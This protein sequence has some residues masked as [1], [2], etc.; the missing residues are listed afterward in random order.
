MGKSK[1]EKKHKDK[2]HKKAKRSSAESSHIINEV[3]DEFSSRDDESKNIVKFT[4]KRRQTK[5]GQFMVCHDS[6]DII[7][8][9]PSKVT[10]NPSTIYET[11]STIFNRLNLTKTS[12]ENLNSKALELVRSLDQFTRA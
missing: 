12:I 3:K 6:D 2:K 11:A 10:S 9:D 5:K 7:E 8:F 1:H 4:Y